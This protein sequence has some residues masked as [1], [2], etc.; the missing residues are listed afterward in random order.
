M[1][2][3]ELKLEN[4]AFIPF[5]ADLGTFLCDKSNRA[6]L[7]PGVDL[8]S[9]HSANCSGFMFNIVM[10]V[11]ELQMVKLGLWPVLEHYV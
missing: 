4:T 10:V 6:L 11:K 8:R 1:L 5:K 9:L 2:H 7:V 3:K